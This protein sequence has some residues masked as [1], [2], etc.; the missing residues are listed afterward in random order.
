MSEKPIGIMIAGCAQQGMQEYVK[1]YLNEIMEKSQHDEGCIIYN[2][3]QSTQNPLE[4]MVYML[5]KSQSL[6]EKHN[7]KP[8]MK[9]FREKLSHD[10]FPLQSPKTFWTLIND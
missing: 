5:W 8:Y 6:F 1:N 9:E 10:L 4:F 3:H 2:I 7:E